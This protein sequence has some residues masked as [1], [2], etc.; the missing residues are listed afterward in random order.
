MRA[1]IYTRVSQDRTGEGASVVRQ[2]AACRGLVAARGW[3]IVGVQRDSLSAYSG[4]HRPG[5]ENVLAAVS[6]RAVDVVV[7]FHV[8]RISRNMGELERLITLAER[9]GVAIATATGDIDLTTDTGRMVARI[10]GAV[11]TQE[12]ERKTA[13]RRLANADRARQGIP[14]AGAPRAFGYTPDGRQVVPAEADAIREGARLILGGATLAAVVRLW[15]GAGLAS[16]GRGA[17]RQGWS[18]AGVRKV[19]RNPRYIGVSIYNGEAVG[20]GAWPAILDEPTH[21][22]LVARL[23]DPARRVGGMSG[24][25]AETLLTG[26]ARCARCERTVRARRSA[27]GAPEY[28]CV[29]GHVY[30]P[31]DQADEW[32]TGWVL[33][34]LADPDVV[35]ALT[36][37]PGAEADAARR[38]S[39]TARQRLDELAEAHARDLITTSQLVSSSALLRERLAAAEGVLARLGSGSAVAPLL[40][41]GDVWERWKVLTLDQRRRLVAALVTVELRSRGRAPF[42]PEHH[43]GVTDI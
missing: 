6:A 32:V 19:L 22:A 30:V 18:P 40:G 7:A 13:R 42:D 21:L 11:A 3:E 25:R 15:E 33:H 43:V 36:S 31:R 34:R 28:A 38:E 41:V 17:T 20:T 23:A 2:E 5:W 14:A 24:R 12:V 37:P 16:S 9:H 29:R 39:T 8:D 26:L 4:A 35:A 10:L 1:I 27:D